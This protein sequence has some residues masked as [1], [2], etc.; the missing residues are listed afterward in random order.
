MKNPALYN[1]ILRILRRL[2][3]GLKES[4]LAS[5]TTVAMDNPRLTT[6]AFADALAFL[7][8]KAARIER[9]QASEEKRQNFLRNELKCWGITDLGRAHL[10]ELDG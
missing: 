3:T 2:D 8:Q 6:D 10:A 4:T 5:E 9:A 1:C 7:E